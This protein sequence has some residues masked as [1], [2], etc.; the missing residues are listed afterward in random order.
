MNLGLITSYIIAALLLLSIL[1][2]NLNVQ[3]SSAELT[4]TQM[5]K[6]RLINI[7]T[8]LNDDLPNMGYDV[9]KSSQE[10]MGSILLDADDNRIEFYRNIQSDLTKDPDRVIWELLDE[11]PPNANNLNVKTLIRVVIDGNTGVPDTTHIR[12][13]VTHFELRYYNTVGSILT[14]N[15]PSPV[16]IGDVKQIHLR[17]ELQADEKLY[18]RASSDGRYVRSVWEKRYT[19]PNLQFN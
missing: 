8:M 10:S 4:I 1:A 3:N 13:G 2:M 17:L 12:S 5:T 7:T 18:N 9:D 6:N 15:M 19:P 11:S 16:T 14:D